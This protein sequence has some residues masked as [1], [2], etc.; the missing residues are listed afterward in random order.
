MTGSETVILTMVTPKGVS[1]VQALA[2]RQAEGLYEAA[3][4]SLEVCGRRPVP[5]SLS[6]LMLSWEDCD[7]K[8]ECTV[9][10]PL[11]QEQM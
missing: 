9:S 8:G 6:V 3:I 10:A 11:P 2:F 4:S 7:L 5:P 1:L